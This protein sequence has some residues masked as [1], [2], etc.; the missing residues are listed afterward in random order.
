MLTMTSDE[1]GDGEDE[2]DGENGKND[3]AAEM[4][5]MIQGFVN[6]RV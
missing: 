2:S 6:R 5:D 4:V 3:D 1:E